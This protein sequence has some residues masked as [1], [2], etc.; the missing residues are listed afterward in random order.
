MA[1]ESPSSEI[2]LAEIGNQDISSLTS[3]ICLQDA[4]DAC[5]KSFESGDFDESSQAVATAVELLDSI[6][7]S[8]HSDSSDA[9][10]DISV[11]ERALEEILSYLSS[12]L[13]NQMVV[14]ALSLELPKVVVKFISLSD[15]C[16]QTAQSIIDG[17]VATCSP[18]DMLAILCEALDSQITVSK[19]PIYFI[20]LL[21]G[22]SKVFLC[23]QRRH[24]EQVKVALPVVL[25]VLQAST[26]EAGEEDKDTLR[27]LFGAAVSIAISIQEV[28]R[29]MVGRIKTEFHAIFGL[30][31]LQNIDLISR[32]KYV[33]TVSSYSSIIMKLLEFLP[34]RGFTFFGL[35][36]GSEVTSL[37]DEL[38]KGDD[39]DNGFLSCFSLAENGSALAVIWAR[40]NDGIAKT[41]TEKL[42]S[43]LTKLQSN[44]TERWTA[45]GMLKPILLSIEYSW[46]IKSH[47]IDLLSMMVPGVVDEQNDDHIDFSSF[48][49]S[50]FTTLQAIQRIMIYATDVPLRKKAFSTFKKLI[51]DLPSAHR[52]DMLRALIT[53]SKSPSMIAILVDL[54]RGEMAAEVN[55]TASSEN[56]LNRHP[57]KKKSS[58]WSSC[59]LNLVEL[60]LKPPKGGPPSFPEDSEPVLSALNLFRFTL[61]TESTRKTN[62]TS[63]MSKHTLQKAY[64]DWLLPLRTLVS[65]VRAETEKDESELSDHILCTLNPVQ[66]VL[67]RCIELVEDNL[68][69]I[70]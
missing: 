57:D 41:D 46:E 59:A 18:R 14:E 2:N 1:A 35:I 67:C 60:I 37:I 42:T 4:L 25:D 10:I 17:L 32:I 63:V 58:F 11:A 68:R 5:L 50:L 8:L 34:F 70:C 3:K 6:A 36:T 29:K 44:R 33:D 19:S 40:I 52:F 45:I 13:S 31:I 16:Q 69:H 30:Y 48:I 9:T 66:L 64:S 54:V 23:I 21:S 27:G 55:W 26:S 65:G 56:D 53:N 39:D 22:I 38:A 61:I 12:P 28:G 15:Q 24:L 62:H 49:P 51:S 47:C 20:P 7:D 43:V